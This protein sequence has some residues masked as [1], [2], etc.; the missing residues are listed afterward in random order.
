MILPDYYALLKINRDSELETI[1]KAFRT[2]IA[3]YHPENNSAPD[4]RRTFDLLIEAFDV[5]SN[6]K[7]RME[8]DVMLKENER[9][10]LPTTVP[11]QKEETYKEWQKEA[12]KKSDKSW[13][14]S[15]DELLL[16][17]VFFEL[18]ILGLLGDW[19]DGL[20]DVF[21]DVFDIF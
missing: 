11:N 8:Y 16:L 19:G 18:G 3:I 2:E 6:D 13:D 1:K 4:A 10:T 14:A 7:K 9:R 20:G 17:E 12:K 15:L 5:L 21:G